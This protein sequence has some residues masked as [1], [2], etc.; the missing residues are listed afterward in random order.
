MQQKSQ[1]IHPKIPDRPQKRGKRG[2]KQH[3][4]SRRAQQDEQPQLALAPA[5]DE[6]EKGKAHGQAVQDVQPG[7]GLWLAQAEGPQQVV[8][9]TGPHPQ[10]N[11]L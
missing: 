1:R 10:K 11:R 9:K 3:R 4:P 2:E 6:Q 8:Q 7:G 5:Q